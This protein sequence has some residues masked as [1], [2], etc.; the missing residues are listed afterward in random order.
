MD[1]DSQGIHSLFSL[2]ESGRAKQTANFAGSLAPDL[3][4]TQTFLVLW[5]LL[6]QP[7]SLNWPP[8]PIHLRTQINTRAIQPRHEQKQS[9]FQPLNILTIDHW[10][11]QRH[12]S[13]TRESAVMTYILAEDELTVPVY[14]SRPK[15]TPPRRRH[16]SS[17]S[18]SKPPKRQRI[19]TSETSSS[20]SI[21]R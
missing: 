15:K 1:A 7:T 21:K 8:S 5:P 11:I 20:G 13:K 14:T 3:I 18:P 9:N 6:R 16:D 12:P 4:Q 2:A 10:A 17:E 19:T